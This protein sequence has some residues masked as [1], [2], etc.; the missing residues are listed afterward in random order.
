VHHFDPQVTNRVERRD[1]EKV[2][3]FLMIGY[4]LVFGSSPFPG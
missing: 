3:R 1:E 4:V 2:G